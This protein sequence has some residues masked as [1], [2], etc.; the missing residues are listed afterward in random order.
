MKKLFSFFA[1]MLVAFVANAAVININTGTAD[2]LRNALNTAS[3]GDVIVMAAGTYVESPSNYIYFIGKEV[4]VMAEEGAEVIVVPKVPIRFKEGARAEFDNIKFDCG[5]LSD[6]NAYSEMI[7][8]ADDTP[9]KRVI[10]RGCEFYGWTQDNAIIHATSSRRLDSVIIDNCYFH[11]NVKSCVFMENPNLIG[12]EITNTT[13][14]DVTTA[15]GYSAGV[16]DVRATSGSVLIDHC[17]FYNCQTKNTDYGVIKVPNAV[18]PVVSNCVFAMPAEYADGRAVYNANGEVN[19]CLTFNYTSDENTGIHSGPT[20]TACIQ[21][22]P[23]FV[24]AP[25]GDLRVQGNSPAIG[26]GTEG[27]DLGDPRWIPHM[28]YYLVGS[29]TEWKAE[30]LYKLSKNPA[31]E[32]EYMIAKTLYAGDEFKI[33]KS[34][35]ITIADTDWYPSGMGN[36][37]QVTASGNYTVY[38]RPDGQG[39][40]GW[41]EGYIYADLDNLG[42]WSSAFSNADWQPE[43]NS[44]LAYDSTA[45]KVTVF[46]RGDK[47]G[48]WQAQVKYQGMPAEDGKCYRV[49]LKMKANHDITGITLKW[50]DDNNTP[51]VIYENQ[52]INLGADNEFIYSE[53]VAG[54]VGEQ[55]SNGIL[56]LDFGFAH[57]GDIIE[58]YGVTI[59]ETACPAPP[60]YYL[61]GSMTEWAAEADYLFAENTEAAG[62]Y[63]LTTTLAVGDAI[64]VV[65][66][67][68]DKETYYPDGFGNEYVVDA[69]HAGETTVYFRPDGNPEW[70]AFGGYFFIPDNGQGIDQI[71]NDRS[72]MTNKVLR[73]GQLLIIK[74]DKTYTTLGTEVK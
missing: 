6:V 22:N 17:T 15:S 64:K 68:E 24:D 74:N 20:I 40:E 65:G 60:V 59:E 12:L 38:F 27:S 61:V 67:Q 37:Y 16:V 62:E 28:E 18:A 7:V 63:F 52:T 31:N 69:A 43:T 58:V 49:A 46:I 13:F 50:Q 71:T 30:P 21:A 23:L 56:V 29:M 53:V 47:S 25:N 3:T 34:D 32:A 19:N 14:A 39:G 73:N 44:Y 9:N 51:N 48:Q 41:H 26:A 10:L 70:A 36:N 33:A 42:P 1:A 66:I 11:N 54:V 2:A 57:N 5:H 4:K 45:E 8:P 72:P 35:G 55:G